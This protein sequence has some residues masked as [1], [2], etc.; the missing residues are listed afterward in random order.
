VAPSWLAG[1]PELIAAASV[2]AANIDF[3]MKFFTTAISP[4]RRHPR[5]QETNT[6]AA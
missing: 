2:A 5:R 3:G 4:L 1:T 6:G